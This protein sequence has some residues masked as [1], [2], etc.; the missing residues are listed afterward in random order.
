MNSFY[1]VLGT[2][3]CRFHRPELAGA[4]TAYGRVI[5]HWTKER[6]ER[7]GH[8]VLYGDTDS[9]FVRLGAP[10]SDAATALARGAE[11]GASVEADLT[12][13][14]EQQWGLESRLELELETCYQRLLLHAT[15][16]GAGGARKRYAGL[17]GEGDDARVVLTGMEAVRSDWTELAKAVQRELY[18]RL[19]RD[20][21]V[22]AYLRRTVAALRDGAFDER[23]VYQKTLRKPLEAY[24]ATTPPHVA[25]ARKLP[26]PPRRSIRYVMTVAGPEPVGHQQNAFDHEHYVSKQ[27]RPVAEPVLEVLG[28][29][30]DRIVG[31]DA[32]LGLFD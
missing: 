4:I 27:I 18:E 15:R 12:R 5:L 11:V 3:A 23:L 25:A 26:E 14:I 10:P 6:F 31:D 7:A 9:L 32:Q 30:F 1:G 28:L 22:D 17:V 16:G 29:D 13:W 2:S 20:R 21:T 24:T 19:F 8:E